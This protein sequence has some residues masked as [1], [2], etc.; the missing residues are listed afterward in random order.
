M[1]TRWLNAT[2][3]CVTLATAALGAIGCEQPVDITPGNDQVGTTQT[4]SA[5]LPTSVPA[6]GDTSAS[7]QQAQG[8]SRDQAQDSQ[9]GQAQGQSQAQTTQSTQRADNGQGQ[10]PAQP[11]QQAPQT[12]A[13]NSAPPVDS[14]GYGTLPM[15]N[16]ET[17][18]GSYSSS[19]VVYPGGTSGVDVSGAAPQTASGSNVSSANAPLTYSSSASNA[20]NNSTSAGAAVIVGA[21]GPSPNGVAPGSPYSSQSVYN[22]SA[23]QSTV[24][25]QQLNGSSN[26]SIQPTNPTAYP[27]NPTAP[28]Q[29]G[30][31]RRG[32]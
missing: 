1:N 15:P 7:A 4:T 19:T 24:I 16:A 9:Q 3:T 2:L 8:T 6:G 20:I 10:Q 27:G 25:Q 21:A 14:S 12:A 22:A 11:Q 29:N 5:E 30:N 32:R 23:T 13:N 28:N 26:S 18:V 31:A 17:S